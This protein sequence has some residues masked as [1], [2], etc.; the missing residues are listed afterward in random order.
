VV[1]DLHVYSAEVCLLKRLDD[2]L[3]CEFVG[4]DPQS[5]S[6]RDG[7]DVIQARLQKSTR[8][9]RDFRICWVIIVR[10]G[11]R[12]LKFIREGLAG[13]RTTVKLYPV[14]FVVFFF[15]FNLKRCH[16]LWM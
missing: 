7:I 6:F 1:D 3:I 16:V 2:P 10:V 15:C 12:L 4:D 5:I 9:P 11:K 13:N 14:M 8:E